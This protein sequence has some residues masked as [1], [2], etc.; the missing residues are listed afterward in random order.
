MAGQNALVEMPILA[1][2]TVE[3]AT[4]DSGV[5]LDHGFTSL[6]GGIGARGGDRAMV[7]ERAMRMQPTPVR[8]EARGREVHV[9]DCM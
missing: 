6:H 3:R 7:E 2:E 9:T 1:C 4:G 8:A 5:E